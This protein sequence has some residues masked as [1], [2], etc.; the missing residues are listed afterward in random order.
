MNVKTRARSVITSGKQIRISAKTLGAMALPTFCERCFQLQLRVQHRL[1]FQIF[2]GIFSSI[3]SYTKKIVHGAFDGNG[4][5]PFWLRELGDL[6]EYREPPHHSKFNLIDH[7]YNIFLTGMPD[8]IFVLRG[9]SFIIVDY[10]TAR[11]TGHQDEL[12]PMYEVQ[13]N[14]YARVAEE[15]GF[16]PV[17]G[18]ALIYMEPMTDGQD[19]CARCQQDGFDMGFSARILPVTLNS[20]LI[21]PLLARTREIHDCVEQQLSAEGCKNCV[22]L[23]ELFAAIPPLKRSGRKNTAKSGR[24]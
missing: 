20:D 13:L 18:L 12:F 1:P 5:P 22:L 15:Y 16:S 19:F 14:V 3:D 2:P 8:G 10:K 9:G 17:S 23:S 6:V 4:S 21:D 11:F 24:R 7:R